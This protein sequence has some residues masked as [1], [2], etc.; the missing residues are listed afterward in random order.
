MYWITYTFWGLILLHALRKPLKIADKLCNFGRW[1]RKSY[2]SKIRLDFWFPF[3]L[4]LCIIAVLSITYY[5]ASNDLIS[6]PPAHTEADIE[7]NP[8][9]F[10]S[11]RVFFSVAEGDWI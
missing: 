5:S 1:I 3:L 11:L 9:I 2:R 6:S 4:A 8:P 7:M 10:E